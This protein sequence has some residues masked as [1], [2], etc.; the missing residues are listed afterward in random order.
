MYVQCFVTIL[1]VFFWGFKKRS[2]FII[3]NNFFDRVTVCEH[4]LMLWQEQSHNQYQSH[5]ACLDES[6]FKC[7]LFYLLRNITYIFY[8]QTLKKSTSVLKRGS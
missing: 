2:Y 5:K 4:L 1:K 8:L 3:L 7:I 6:H